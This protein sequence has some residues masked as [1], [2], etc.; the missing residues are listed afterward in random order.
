MEGFPFLKTSY[1]KI[2]SNVFMR[3]F[4]ILETPTQSVGQAPHKE[5]RY[6]DS[7][8]RTKFRS[9][10]FHRQSFERSHLPPSSGEHVTAIDI[11]R[12][13]GRGSKSALLF[14]PGEFI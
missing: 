5:G 14:R 7:H 9:V 12:T 8:A 3:G 4:P 6:E 13:R 10:Q 11:D 1:H 2:L